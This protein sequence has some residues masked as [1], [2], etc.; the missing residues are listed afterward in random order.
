MKKLRLATAVAAIVFSIATPS[1]AQQKTELVFW[2]QES[3]PNRVEAYQKLIDKFNAANPTIEV[4]QE[5]QDWGTIFQVAPAAIGSGTGPDILMAM[6]ELGTYLR[7]TGAVQPVSDFV[8]ELDG[9]YHFLAAATDP[10]HDGGQ[11]WGVPLWGMVQLL[12][13]RKSAFEEAKITKAPATWEEVAEDAAKLTKGGRYGIT[14]PASKTT[15]TDQTFFSFLKTYKGENLFDADGKII[16][17][18]PNAVRAVT[19]YTDLLKYAAPDSTNYAWGEPEAAFNSGAAAMLID[20]GIMLSIFLKDS[21]AP[22]E[23]LGCAPIPEPAEGGQPGSHYASNAAM[24]LTKDPAKQEAA[25]TFIRFLLQPD[26]YGPLLNAEPGL[27]LPVTADGFKLASWLADPALTKWP[28]C[29]ALL[30]KQSESGGLYGF[31]GGMYQINIG[32]IAGQNI[33][34]Q[35]IQKVVID[36]ASPKDAVAWGADQ[37]RAAIK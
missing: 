25:K 3:P 20:K 32:P 22:A 34:A 13:Y 9:Q 36:H 11:Y 30:A 10:Y 33:I 26:N 31:T 19:T 7:A 29:T 6:P 2:H 5:V 12:W 8:K 21:G 24:I 16:F 37:M 14:L 1:F 28:E 27:F 4:R 15:A 18:N 35:V 23:D 17:D